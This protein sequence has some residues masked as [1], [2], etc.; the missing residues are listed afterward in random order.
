MKILKL[1]LLLGSVV[2]VSC[3]HTPS[4]GPVVGT[5][6]VAF[7][8]AARNRD[9]TS[10]LWFEAGADAKVGGFSARPPIRPIFIAR[11]ARP[12]D[13][14][15]KR[16]LIVLSHGNWG[17]RYSLGWL[18]V[19]L[20]RAGYVVVSVSHPG[21]M[22]EGQT[23]EGR[24]RLWDRSRDVSVVLDQ[25]LGD[26]AWSRLIDADRIGFVGHSFGGFAGV[27]LAG[28]VWDPDKQKRFCAAHQ[29]DMYCKTSAAEDT[30]V[31]DRHDA[32]RPYRDQRIKAFY[33]MAAGPAQGFTPE[34]LRAITAP[35]LVDSA[36]HDDILDYRQN[37]QVFATQVKSAREIERDVGHF[38]YVPECKAVIGKLLAR[39]I[40][41]DPDGVD[42][43]KAHEDIRQSVI[44][45]F[46]PHL[47]K[48]ADDRRAESVER[49]GD[50]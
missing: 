11:D 48:S 1:V 38:T 17:T 46:G 41:E 44:A 13:G 3:A 50:R 12:R 34:S 30:S 4:E 5:R 39:Q 7:R 23:V 33:V 32:L 45:F 21:T 40:C 22:N 20:V 25:L 36:K 19:H 43:A 28:G 29:N 42:R 49:A 15:G 2:F 8:D 14:V 6:T 10:E 31:F 37:A 26:P 9:L 27:S 16:P 24:F 18:A 35:M 47:T